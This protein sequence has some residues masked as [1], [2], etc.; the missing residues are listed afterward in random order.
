MAS[1]LKIACLLSLAAAMPTVLGAALD[2]TDSSSTTPTTTSSAPVATVSPY[3]QCGGQGFT[4]ATKCADGW[5]CQYENPWYQNCFL[6]PTTT[7]PATATATAL[8]VCGGA[9]WTG[10]TACPD[11]Y[12]CTVV[13]TWTSD[14]LSPSDWY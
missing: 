10:P 9:G 6:S 11:G 3:G 13:S 12:T 4:G 2:S 14:C 7:A 1:L 5:Y 8:G